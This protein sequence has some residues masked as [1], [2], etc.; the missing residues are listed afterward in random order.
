MD[1]RQLSAFLAVVEHGT[2]T[3]AAAAVH[4][5]QPALSQTIRSLEAELGTPLFHRIG[6]RLVLT[7]AGEALTGPARQVLRDLDRARRAVTDVAGVAGGVLDVVVLPTLAVDPAAALLGRFRQAHPGVSL[8]LTEPDGTADALGR[9]ADGR[10]ELA[11]TDAEQAPGLVFHHLVRQ[12]YRAVFPAGAAPGR[13]R[14]IPL[15]ALVG[16][17]FVT[18]P[19]GT[20]S[21][22]LL[23]RA[24]EASGAVP[25]V[26]V[27][28]GPREAILPL[29]VAGAGAALLPVSLALEAAALGADVRELDPPITREVTLANRDAPI[30]PAAAALLAL[31]VG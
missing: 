19:P 5:S 8:R 3:A 2:V 24:H 10:A 9:V 23:E 29:V 16:M 30:S 15:A 26:V 12:E 6:R 22:R 1:V 18:T 27:E 7:S 20:S 17:P 28:A 21:R 31:A 11:L 13:R 14:T 4:V 25:V